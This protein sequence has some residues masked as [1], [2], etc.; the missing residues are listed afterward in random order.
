MSMQFSLNGSDWIITG[1][2][3]NQWRLQKSIELRQSLEAVVR[4]IPGEVPGAVNLDLIRA[5]RL[6]DPNY[7]LNSI[8]GEW[9]TNREWFYEKD[10]T[11][12]SGMRGEKYM[13]VFKGLDFHGEIYLNGKRLTS[14]Y[15]MFKP[16]EID[17]TGIVD[18]EDSNHLTVVFFRSPEVYGQFGWTNRIKT[19]K[20]RFNYIWDWCPRIV[21]V[22]IWD[23][24]FI[25]VYNRT[26]IEDFYPKAGISKDDSAMD[27]INSPAG[28]ETD[29]EITGV[30]NIESTMDAAVP[31]EYT[32]NYQ[33]FHE[34]SEV[35][36]RQ[37]KV[38]LLACRQVVKSEIVLE[39]P[40]LWWPNGLGSQPL[41]NVKLTVIN[42]D[43]LVC[44]DCEKRIGFRSVEF[45]QNHG[46][47]PDARPYTM[48]VN[49]RRVFLKGVNW[50]PLSPF[51]GA[52]KKSEYRAYLK[53][54]K[55]MNCN[56]LRIWGGAI[57]EKQAF[58]DLCD[59][60]GLMVWQEF[61]QS[62]SGLNNAPSDDPDFLKELEQAAIHYIKEKRHHAC[63]VIWCGGNELMGDNYT[64]SDENHENLNMLKGLVDR[65][66][67][68]KY[69][70]PTS[71][72]GPTFCADKRDFGKGVHHDVHGPWN[73]LENPEHYEFFDGDDSLFRS[74]TGC[75]GI[76]RYETLEK[77]RGDFPLWPP[78]HD[79][80]YWVHRGAWWIQR[81]QLTNLFGEWKEDGSELAEYI[82]SSR[83]IQAEALRYAVEATRRREPASSG[84][85]I[86]MGNEPF[87]NNSNTSVIEFDGTPKPAYY[88]VKKAY[89]SLHASLRH[90]KIG[91][92]AGESFVGEVFVHDEFGNLSG[93]AEIKADIYDIHGN[94][95]HSYSWK[96][97]SPIRDRAAAQAG[98]VEWRIAS[99][100]FD[101]FVIRVSVL[102]KEQVLSE[103]NY[104]FTIGSTQVFKPL[105]DLPK[106]HIDVKC[107][108][109]PSGFEWIVSNTS[110]VA[111]LGVF[112]YGKDPAKFLYVSD[113]YLTLMP[114]E[115][116]RVYISTGSGTPIQKDDICIE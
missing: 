27:M 20:S 66:D 96:P 38:N 95:L 18:T 115:Q 63:H 90:Q 78:D 94:R 67:N 62:S 39:N 53:R 34:G 13:L 76:S 44:D 83:F 69:F 112:I 64:P 97:N 43:G 110:N 40:K 21:P 52:V 36:A 31:G 72:S 1:W 6:P 108:Q 30:I 9:V 51:Y 8:L 45:V 11:I 46:A 17:I 32:F 109:S 107:S 87:P 57:L 7:G 79:N 25:K 10:F 74:E 85:I 60:M 49:G 114:N 47:S 77:Y 92:S 61:P 98:T 54:F 80:P 5:G 116:K 84:F 111:A 22:G 68:G 59:E 113:N 65:L 29:N 101:I 82:R 93:D 103:N 12:P 24:V 105:R 73:Y 89:S 71:A 19:V 35:Y 2:W 86:W 41:Y 56:L 88:W 106:C 48:M 3:E 16:V 50:V 28:I 70:L 23:D 102:E 26:R 42:G 33:V 4:N 15:G 75:P 99:C 37:D 58:Y 55:D 104:I 14:F 100:P 91:Y 81:T